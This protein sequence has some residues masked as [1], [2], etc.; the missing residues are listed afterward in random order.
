VFAAQHVNGSTRVARLAGTPISC[1][2]WLTSD[3]I[4]P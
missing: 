1:A 2:R 4:T 3:D